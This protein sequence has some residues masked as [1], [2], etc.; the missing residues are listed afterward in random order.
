MDGS[1]E[2]TFRV[3]GLDEIR[4]WILSFGP[5]AFAVEPPELVAAVAKSHQQALEQYNGLEF[6]SADIQKEESLQEDQL[7]E[8]RLPFIFGRK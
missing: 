4:Q 6:P 3:A 7:L 8:N 1:I 2:I 5:E